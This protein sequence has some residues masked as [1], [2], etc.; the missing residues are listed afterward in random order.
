MPQSE[1]KSTNIHQ[2]SRNSNASNHPAAREKV[3]CNEWERRNNSP[4]SC[5]NINPN[6]VGL[7]RASDRS[8]RHIPRLA[9]RKCIPK[10]KNDSIV[11]AKTGRIQRYHNLYHG[12]GRS[13]QGSLNVAAA[14]ALLS[15]QQS[16]PRPLP[17]ERG[18]SHLRQ[19]R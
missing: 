19:K 12:P 17:G 2:E 10:C 1:N 3:V 14:R 8:V 18:R 11:S 9:P 16:N 6:R 7:E 4:R 15:D 5:V 13:Q